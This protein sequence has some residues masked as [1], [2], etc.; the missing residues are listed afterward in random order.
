VLH[1]T[2]IEE[3]TIA[4]FYAGS[5]LEL[6]YEDSLRSPSQNW[7]PHKILR[8]FFLRIY[9]G[10]QNFCGMTV[11][12]EIQ[13]YTHMNSALFLENFLRVFLEDL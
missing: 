2:L 4:R 10:E 12:W 8:K 5:G 3:G 11:L 7:I 1:E 6:S 9:N 13:H